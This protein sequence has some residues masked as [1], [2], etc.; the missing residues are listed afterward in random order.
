MDINT[1]RFSF[2]QIQVGAN[3]DDGF[4]V[5]A[6]FSQRTYGF[7][8]EPYATD[9][10]F[11]AF[12]SLAGEVTVFKYDGE[13]NHITRNIDLVLKGESGYPE[14]NNFFGLGNRY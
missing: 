14:V 7:R 3:S 5:G 13:F 11:A 4:I 10:K 2:P 1:T 6:G 12:Y 8:N 9:Q